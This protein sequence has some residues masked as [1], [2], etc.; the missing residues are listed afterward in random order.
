MKILSKLL[1]S[2]VISFTTFGSFNISAQEVEAVMPEVIKDAPIDSKYKTVQYEKLV[3]L[4]IESIK[5]LS[6]QV[7]I[8]QKENTEIKAIIKK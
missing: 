6:S 1:L 8:L 7:K 3:P 5:E 2:F 4:L